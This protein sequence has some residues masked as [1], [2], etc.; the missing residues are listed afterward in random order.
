[1]KKLKCRAG[2]NCHKP[3]SLKI[4]K[5]EEP[6]NPINFSSI[7]GEIPQVSAPKGKTAWDDIS[8]KPLKDLTK[9]P[10][11]PLK[12]K[13]EINYQ[14]AKSFIGGVSS[15]MQ[16][17]NN[18]FKRSGELANNSN[19]QNPNLPKQQPTVYSYIGKR[20]TDFSIPRYEN[21]TSKNGI[22]F[23]DL[24][25]G[26][27]VEGF[28]VN[29]KG[30]QQIIFNKGVIGDVNRPDFGQIA[31]GKIALVPKRDSAFAVEVFHQIP[32]TPD[33]LRK[34]S[35]DTIRKGQDNYLNYKNYFEYTKPKA[36]QGAVPVSWSSLGT[37][38]IKQ[39]LASLGVN[40]KNIKFNY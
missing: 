23:I 28:K 8:T 26:E 17:A 15:L 30:E 20:A 31:Q 37:D 5:D 12:K 29:D 21:G 7:F 16:G 4:Q 14:L 11:E 22:Y 19:K 27:D 35:S 18:I 39:I 6:A 38:K 9:A 1:M 33:S 25:F 13:P 36:T 24:P 34:V 40:I 2:C 10:T 32:N 3:S